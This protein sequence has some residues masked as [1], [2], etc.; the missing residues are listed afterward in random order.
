[1]RRWRKAAGLSDRDSRAA[2]TKLLTEMGKIPDV[3]IELPGFFLWIENGDSPRKF[4]CQ[5]ESTSHVLFIIY[6]RAICRV[7]TVPI[8]N[9]KFGSDAMPGY[10]LI[11]GMEA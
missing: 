4:S 11:D 5:V 7:G 8:F 9:P 10:G 2:E 1:V 6:I 3:R